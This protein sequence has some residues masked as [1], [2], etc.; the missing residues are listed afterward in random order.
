MKKTG[1][2]HTQTH[3]L[4]KMK[5]ESDD[6][7]TSSQWANTSLVTNVQSTDENQGGLSPTTRRWNLRWARRIGYQGTRST[8]HFT[9]RR[10]SVSSEH[11]ISYLHNHN[12]HTNSKKKKHINASPIHPI[13]ASYTHSPVNASPI[14]LN[15]SLIHSPVNA[16]PIYLNASPIHSINASYIHS[17][18]NA[19]PIHPINA[20]YTH[21]T[22]NASPILFWKRIVYFLQK[23]IKA[24]LHWAC[25]H[26]FDTWPKHTNNRTWQQKA[27]YTPN[28]HPQHHNTMLTLGRHIT[29]TAKNISITT[30]KDQGSTLG[31]AKSAQNHKQQ[32]PRKSVHKTGQWEPWI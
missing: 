30:T 12:S 26:E 31:S 14:H 32:T 20:S 15:A 19:P 16:S 25:T 22:L 5:Q 28:Q 7:K 17:L 13:N 24:P 3:T 23:K 2:E 27:S 1:R 10:T 8:L 4:T 29:N 9:V 6:E 18:L 21:S 11:D